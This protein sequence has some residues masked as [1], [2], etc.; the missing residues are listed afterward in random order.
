MRLVRSLSRLRAAHAAALALAALLMPCRPAAA[1]AD[2]LQKSLVKI[3]TTAQ[4]Q[5]YYEPWRVNAQQ[6]WSGSGCVIAGN[7]ILTNAHVVSDAIFIEVRKEGDSQK[8]VARREYVA[9]DCDLALLKVDDPAFFRGTRPVTFGGLPFKRD[10]VAVYGFPV[11]GDELSVTEGVV[12]RIELSVYAHSWKELLNVQ[13]DAA[14][15]PGNSGGPVF[16]G[17]KVVGV[18]FQGYN[19]VVAQNTGFFVPVPIIRRFLDET[20]KGAYRE[21][22][23]F[24][25]SVEGLENPA[26][27][28]FY[29][30]KHGQSGA[31][32]TRVSYG[33]SAWGLLQPG[34]VL[35]SFDGFAVANDRTIGFRKGERIGFA[36]PLGLHHIGESIKVTVLR[37]RRTLALAMPLKEPVTLVPLPA[38]DRKPTYFIFD[39]LVFTPFNMNYPGVTDSTPPELKAL[40]FHDVPTRERRQV[41]LLNHILSHVINKGYGPSF[42]D[43]IVTAVNGHPIGDMKELVAAFKDP[44]DGRHVIEIDKAKEAGTRIVLDAAQSGQASA[45]IL[46]EYGVP[47]DRSPDLAEAAP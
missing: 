47:A 42:N 32:V 37:K 12:S 41:V 36:Y 27:R 22:P 4:E 9:H 45:E 20:R 25:A 6:Q 39:G 16:Q 11:G 3:Y 2:L 10:K 15:N 43:V 23:G 30:M 46:R 29:G 34:D 13:T 28:A 33:S 8:Y 5:N 40:C 18:A 31:L 38:H 44:K 21:I 7:R 26:L 35:L 14:I 1:A 19:A 17:D 24:G